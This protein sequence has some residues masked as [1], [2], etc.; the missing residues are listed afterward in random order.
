[1]VD[2]FNAQIDEIGKQLE[3]ATNKIYHRDHKEL[4]HHLMRSFKTG[5]L[6]QV[7]KERDATVAKQSARIKELEAKLGGVK[8]ASKLAHINPTKKVETPEID[9]LEEGS[10]EEAFDKWNRDRPR[11]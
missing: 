11:A 8:E 5:H 2:K 1:V 3:Q 9:A 4:A 6:E 10:A 7:L